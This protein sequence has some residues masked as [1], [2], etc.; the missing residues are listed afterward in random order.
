[1]EFCRFARF[2]VLEFGGFPSLSPSLEVCGVV[3]LK[4]RMSGG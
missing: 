2:G 3:G 4:V 1:M